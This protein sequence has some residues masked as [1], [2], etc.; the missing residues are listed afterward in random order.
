MQQLT[1]TL[2]NFSRMQLEINCNHARNVRMRE[3]GCW[4]RCSGA[5]LAGWGFLYAMEAQGSQ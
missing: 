5:W 2:P 1:D 3:V 4:A